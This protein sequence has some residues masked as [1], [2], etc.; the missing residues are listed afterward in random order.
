MN[1]LTRKIKIVREARKEIMKK[2]DKDI[3]K[4]FS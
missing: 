3:I 4:N 1:K 2:G